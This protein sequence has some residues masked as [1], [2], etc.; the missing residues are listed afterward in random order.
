MRWST[1]TLKELRRE[2]RNVRFPLHILSMTFPEG[3]F[4]LSFY[5]L[6]FRDCCVTENYVTFR[7]LLSEK[8]ESRCASTE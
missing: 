4:F 8:D 7:V 5:F 6:F 3:D 1:L 2:N